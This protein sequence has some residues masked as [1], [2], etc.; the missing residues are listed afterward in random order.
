MFLFILK[1]DQ[2]PCFLF[3]N[4]HCRAA[5]S[6][7]RFYRNRKGYPDPPPCSPTLQCQKNLYQSLSSIR[8]DYETYLRLRRSR[9]KNTLSVKSSSYRLVPVDS[10]QDKAFNI[11]VCDKPIHSDIS[12]ELKKFGREM[13]LNNTSMKSSFNYKHGMSIPEKSM[14]SLNSYFRIP[15]IQF[16]EGPP[17]QQVPKNL[18]EIAA[19][20][21]VASNLKGS[22]GLL[23]SGP[24]MIGKYY[25]Q[26]A[27]LGQVDTKRTQDG[28]DTSDDAAFRLTVRKPDVIT[29][30]PLEEL[31]MRT[32]EGA[33]DIRGAKKEID[34][35]SKSAPLPAIKRNPSTK[36]NHLQRSLI[37]SHTGMNFSAFRVVEK[38]YKDRDQA[39]RLLRKSHVVKQIKKQEKSA[40]IKV[41]RTKRNHKNEACTQKH[42]DRARVLQELETRRRCML[43][44]QDEAAEKRASRD[45][46]QRRAKV[47]YRFA[48]DFRS[49]NAS[50]GK[51]L[52]S[53][54]YA[55]Q[56]SDTLD[57]MMRRVGEMRAD[58]L[59][60]KALLRE[61]NEQKVLIKQ[62]D[63]QADRADL[64][65]KLLKN[66]AKRELELRKH[67]KKHQEKELRQL[68][69][70]TLLSVTE[71]QSRNV[72]ASP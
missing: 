30:E 31:I 3:D 40:Q 32:M 45:E 67:L 37:K 4:F 22:N 71:I 44:T 6:I 47:N 34:R 70:P 57:R 43:E 68:R 33:S 12:V 21:G 48:L 35:I 51:A 10:S 62:A 16:K 18:Q 52:T 20:L 5:I 72:I 65:M 55:K 36:L 24:T 50:V 41:K 46:S 25:T 27:F 23:R 29:Q 26:Y 9:H 42:A 63:V 8:L 38:A 64:D 69:S 14:S 53:H 2:L 58:S 54:A 1:H 28:R 49:Q 59:D 17:T 11:G 7:Q 60:K 56:R 61:F 66:S 13:I 39:E 19:C 15:S